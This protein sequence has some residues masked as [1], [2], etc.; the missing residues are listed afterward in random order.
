MHRL[1]IP[2]QLPVALAEYRAIG[3]DERR[4]VFEIPATSPLHRVSDA[5]M[6]AAPSVALGKLA[7]SIILDARIPVAANVEIRK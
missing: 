5:D 7:D 3:R 2:P 1:D 6:V 4:G